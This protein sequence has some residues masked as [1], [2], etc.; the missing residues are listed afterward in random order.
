MREEERKRIED[1]VDSIRDFFQIPA[2]I[3]DID[4]I[5]KKLD[6]TIEIVEDIISDGKLEMSS[7]NSEGKFI[8]KL[9]PVQSKERRNFTIAHELG[10]LFLHTNYIESVLEDKKL[11]F[12][13]FYRSGNTKREY[14]ANEFAANLLTPRK[15]FIETIEENTNENKMVDMER[16]ANKFGVSIDMAVTRGRWMGLLGW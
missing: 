5:V 1:I 8:I 11:T 9:S 15:L 16:V 3:G 7:N 14:Q 2:P 4:E 10:H 6:G 13:E 12:G